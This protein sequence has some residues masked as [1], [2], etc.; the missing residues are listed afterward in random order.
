[1]NAKITPHFETLPWSGV[2]PRGWMKAQLQRDLTEGFAGC[3][4]TLTERAATDLFRQR[5]ESS[6][7]QFAWWDSETRGNWLWGY[8]MMAFLADQPKH[9]ARV[10]ALLEDLK[11]T[12]DAD[13]YLGIYSPASRYA[14]GESENGELWA[15]SRALLAL[16][17]YHEFSGDARYL[18]AVRRAVDLTLRHY[19]SDRPY[20]HVASAKD[21]DASTGLTHGLCY[22]DVVEWLYALTGDAR[23]RDFGV[24]L[25]EDFSRMPLPFPSDD[26]ALANV[27]VRQRPL[28]GHA[29]HTV[30]HLRALL[31]AAR[32]SSDPQIEIAAQNA[33]WKLRRY[34]L[35]SG[36]VIGDESIHGLP[37]PDMGYE[38]CTLTELLFSLTSA[39]QKTGDSTLGDWIET[40]AFNAG[41]GAR[42]ADGRG[43]SYLTTD[44]RLAAT[45]D[46]ADSYSWL[47]DQHGRFKYSPTHEDVACCCNPNAVRFLPHTI[48]RMWLRASDGLAA[49]TYGPCQLT[50]DVNGVRVVITEE[51]AYP[52]SDVVCFTIAPERGVNFTLYLRR[53]AWAS[54]IEISGAVAHAAEGYLAIDRVWPAESAVELTFKTAVQVRPYPAGEYAVQRGPLQYVLPMA[55]TLQPIKDYPLAPF[56]DYNVLP[57]NIE[58]ACE[59]VLLDE[60]QPDYGLSFE[61]DPA[62]DVD[63][64]WEQSPVRLRFGA[65]ALV[66]LGCTVLRRASFPL[67]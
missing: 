8:T 59:C 61:A 65:T 58:Q 22:V 7:Q 27:L 47:N 43:V 52:F 26:L 18:D 33:L 12:Q 39:L 9:K 42:L 36:A 28:H 40:L 6:S 35:P 67:K 44:T 66:P 29:V 62:I 10:T 34:A 19:S 17:T 63:R 25:Y 11:D 15:Q 4:D 64:C 55:H 41:Q 24:W 1:M 20:F 56:H 38:Y 37:T 2:R 23:Y 60:S 14:H 51:T 30:E 16:L 21:R 13:G 54:S 48:S 46:R 49:V 57:Q 50:T 3:L 45:T 5:S 53:P 32:M 31:W